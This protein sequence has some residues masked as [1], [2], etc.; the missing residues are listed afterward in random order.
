MQ[1]G[2]R[3]EAAAALERALRLEPENQRSLQ[4]EK[5]IEET[6]TARAVSQP[7]RS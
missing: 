5:L 3:E 4:L 7:E 6:E 1:L 2:R